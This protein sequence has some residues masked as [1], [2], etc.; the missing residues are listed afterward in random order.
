MNVV[1]GVAAGRDV[2]VQQRHVF[3]REHRPVIRRLHDWDR[4]LDV[5]RR[6]GSCERGGGDGKRDGD[7][8]HGYLAYQ[9]PTTNYCKG[10]NA[11]ALF[12]FIGITS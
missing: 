11:I 4:P 3:V 9:S 2:D 10:M 6:H 12:A 1:A 7:L 5:L 8:L